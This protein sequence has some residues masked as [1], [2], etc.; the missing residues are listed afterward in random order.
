MALA[1]QND[2]QHNPGGEEETIRICVLGASGVGKSS[3]CNFLSDSDEFKV[4]G[5]F[6]SCTQQS[7][8]HM[9]TYQ[10]NHNDIHFEI[11]DTPGWFD[12]DGERLPS[13]QVMLNKINQCLSISNGGITAYFIV[14]PF[15]RISIDTEQAIYFMRDCFDSSQLKHVYMV[16]TKCNGNS[17]DEILESLLAQK[18]KGRKASG[19][20]YNYAQQINEQ[21]FAV[22][23]N[24]D[25][26]CIVSDLYMIFMFC[27][28]D[29][30]AFHRQYEAVD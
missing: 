29:K 23:T 21:C 17:V 8:S 10:I 5:G 25:G 7:S 2:H 4:G 16:F 22:D 19:L 13:V 28:L 18:S 11:T 27:S 6:D 30:V 15:E 26:K 14:V 1:Q 12:A 3:L 20:V 9:F 24:V